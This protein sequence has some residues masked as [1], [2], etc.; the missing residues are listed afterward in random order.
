MPAEWAG[1]PS[2]HASFARPG[3]FTMRAHFV[4]AI[5]AILIAGFVVTLSSFSRPTADG[6][7]SPSRDV[8]QTREPAQLPIQKIHDM[9]VVFSQSD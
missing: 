6:V 3:R 9:S 1:S 5:T 4:I 7:K 8:S 2:L